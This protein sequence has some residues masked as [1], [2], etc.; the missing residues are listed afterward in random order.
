MCKYYNIISKLLDEFG[1]CSS[2][3][4]GRKLVKKMN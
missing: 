1:S 3:R 4:N 2:S